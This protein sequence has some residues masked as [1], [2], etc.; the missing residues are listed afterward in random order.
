[1]LI[2]VLFEIAAD[3]TY[4]HNFPEF[5]KPSNCGACGVGQ[6]IIVKTIPSK[7]HL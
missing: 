3:H 1:M 2:L 5:T 7:A 6:V 4:S